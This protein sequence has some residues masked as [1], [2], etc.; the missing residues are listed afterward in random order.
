MNPN[1][2]IDLRTCKPGQKLKSKHGLILTYVAHETDSNYPWK[3]R[4]RYPD[5]GIGSRTD[6]GFVMNHPAS[7]LD[8]DHDI[9]EILPMDA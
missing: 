5:G 3:H 4:V 6:D 8:A 1:P 2:S 9:V 7:R